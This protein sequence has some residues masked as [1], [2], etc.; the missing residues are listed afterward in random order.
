MKKSNAQKESMSLRRRMQSSVVLTTSLA[1]VRSGET[2]AKDNSYHCCSSFTRNN[3]L[4]AY[5]IFDLK[6]RHRWWLCSSGEILGKEAAIYRYLSAMSSRRQDHF[7]PT[8][9]LWCLRR[10][11]S[12]VD[13]RSWK[14]Q[15]HWFEISQHICHAVVVLFIALSKEPCVALLLHRRHHRT[16]FLQSKEKYFSS[17][18]VMSRKEVMEL[19]PASYYQK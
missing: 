2:L 11:C 7:M 16:D 13:A 1:R 8:T 17:T 5:G 15:I 6:Y 14:Q 9:A 3:T 19:A 12:S 18:I 10:C 4:Y